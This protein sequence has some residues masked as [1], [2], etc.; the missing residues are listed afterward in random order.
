M[1]MQNDEAPFK[2]V[3]AFEVSKAELVAHRLPEDEQVSVPNTP[4]GVRRVLR[5]WAKEAGGL[6]IV[7]EATG[8]YERAVL[9]ESVAADLPVHRAHGS[10]TRSYA[11]YIGQLASEAE[12][13][14]EPA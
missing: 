1:K 4:V 13:W 5:R 9:A 8:G 12:P 2:R 3:I 11:R 14:A 10:R 7:C 6:L